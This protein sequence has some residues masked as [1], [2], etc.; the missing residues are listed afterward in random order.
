MATEY[1]SV[2]RQVFR[3]VNHSYIYLAVD[4]DTSCWQVMLRNEW[5]VDL[6]TPLLQGPKFLPDI[7]PARCFNSCPDK[8]WAFWKNGQKYLDENFQNF[9][10]F[11]CETHLNQN[12]S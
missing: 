1:F 11:S 9:Q 8:K 12:C 6:T 5:N 7:C 4:P 3:H 2:G 10:L